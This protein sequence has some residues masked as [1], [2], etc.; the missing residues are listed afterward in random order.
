MNSLTGPGLIVA[1]ALLWGLDGILRRSLQGV[2]PLTIVF[3]EHLLGLVL[4][5]PFV[6]RSRKESFRKSE[7]AALGL[8]SLFSGL[9]GTLW[10]TTALLSTNFIPFSVVFLLQKLQPVF[11]IATA[12]ILLKEKINRR[13]IL[14]AGIAL[15]AAYFVTFPGGRVNLAAG[16]GTLIAGLFAAGA[17]FAWGTSTAFS[18][19]ALLRHSPTLVTGIRFALTIV[20]AGIWLLVSGRGLGPAGFDN[21]DWLR[22]VFIALTSGMV[23]LWIYYRGLKTTRVAVSTILELFYPLIAVVIDIF[24]YKTVLHWSQYAAAAVLLFASYKVARLNAPDE[25]SR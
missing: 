14:F 10:F 3:Y 5:L 6:L 15:V 9:L 1:A 25:V 11:A 22:L 2:P 7:W 12:A 23:A 19:L 21:G 13:Y 24:L 4:L 16:E 20:F 8:V 18:R 17:A